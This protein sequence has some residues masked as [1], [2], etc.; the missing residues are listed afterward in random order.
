MKFGDTLEVQPVR[1]QFLD[2][3][4]VLDD[5]ALTEASLNSTLPSVIFA[6]SSQHSG[7]L[8]FALP[9]ASRGL[10][11]EGGPKKVKTV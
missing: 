3:P 6:A 8:L 2:H 10:R 11:L 1:Q 5:T 9:T 4:G 7:D